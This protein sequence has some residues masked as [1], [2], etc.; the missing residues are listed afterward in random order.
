MI[1]IITTVAVLSLVWIKNPLAARAVIVAGVC[2][3]LWLSEVVP[4]FV[5]TLALWL[6]SRRLRI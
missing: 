5:P 6:F 2:L 4:P 1:V 3:T